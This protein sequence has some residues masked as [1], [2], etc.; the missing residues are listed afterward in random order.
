MTSGRAGRQR[1]RLR[2]DKSTTEASGN[3]GERGEAA[4]RRLTDPLLECAL[5]AAAPSIDQSLEIGRFS[6]AVSFL[7]PPL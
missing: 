5:A 7:S 1:E 2:M 6:R 4:A 3:E